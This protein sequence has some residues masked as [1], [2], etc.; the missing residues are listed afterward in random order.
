MEP[1]VPSPVG[2]GA[3][4]RRV[5]PASSRGRLL[6]AVMLQVAL[7]RLLAV[8]AG[9]EVM[10]VREMG[11]M[12]GLLVRPGLVVLGRFLVVPRGVLMV[13]GSLLVVFR[14]L[15]GHPALPPVPEFYRAGV[16]IA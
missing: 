14:S 8:V 12:R 1:R 3:A 5:C 13:F 15:L 6:L 4:E 16:T 2:E 9:M 11:M 7:G 10:A